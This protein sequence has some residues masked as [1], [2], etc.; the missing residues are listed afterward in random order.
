MGGRCGVREVVTQLRQVYVT[1]S[2]RNARCMI[3]V[4]SCVCFGPCW[5]R[6]VHS[7]GSF[8]MENT[9]KKILLDPDQ[10]KSEKLINAM[11]S[12][13]MALFVAADLPVIC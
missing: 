11:Q 1:R 7:Q 9:T 4:D 5:D 12:G 8:P 10:G 6:E 13:V 3:Y 2:S